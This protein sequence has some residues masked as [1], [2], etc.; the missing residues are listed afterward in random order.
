M[1]KIICAILI[2][3]VCVSDGYAQSDSI[4]AQRK[5]PT[6]NGHAF[7]SVGYFRNPF[8]STNLQANIGFGSTSPLVIPGIQINDEIDILTFEGQLIFIDINLQYQQRFTPWL[9]M[10]ITTKLATRVGSDMSTIIAD[11]INTISGGE[12]GW[13]VRIVE[14][15]KFYLSGSIGLNNLRGRFINVTD[16]LKEIIDN[17]PFPSLTKSVPAM[18]VGIGLRGAYAFNSMFGL[19][20]EANYSYGEAFQRNESNGYYAI[21]IVGD[22]DFKPKQNVPIGL[23]LGYSR[24]TAPEIVMSE[25]G[26]SN[27]LF[28]K[29]GYT[30]SDD[31]DLGLQ[32]T[33]YN[34]DV[35]SLKDD[36]YI[37][38]VVLALK[39]Y[40]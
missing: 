31:F 7:P 38:K 36:P 14:R 39:F 40:F 10:F 13:L 32:F 3:L 35:A 28:A 20:F 9:A 6:L 11:G 23:A 1:K 12:I 30:G 22:V 33:Y 19:Q 27:L 34:I 8:V 25:E 37:S 29:I 21:G 17:D 24:T 18:Q 15:D 2:L 26:L 16:Y 5:I 4:T